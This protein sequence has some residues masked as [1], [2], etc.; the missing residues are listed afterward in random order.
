MSDISIRDRDFN[1]NIC[2]EKKPIFPKL[3]IFGESLSV[4]HGII[5]IWKHI[6]CFYFAK[7]L[8]SCKKVQPSF[9]LQ[10]HTA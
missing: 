1:Q 2:Y 5:N 7:K 9:F 6:I 10:S 3:F 4:F 8:K